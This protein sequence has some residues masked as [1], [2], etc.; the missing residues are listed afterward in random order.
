MKQ[1]YAVQD[2]V[3]KGHIFIFEVLC[4]CLQNQCNDIIR[5]CTVKNTIG[6][7]LLFLKSKFVKC[8]LKLPRDSELAGEVLFLEPEFDHSQ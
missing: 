1:K 6:L 8:K 3:L 5:F 4:F 2:E 7:I